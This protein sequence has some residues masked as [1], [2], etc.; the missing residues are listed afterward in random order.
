MKVILEPPSFMVISCSSVSP[1]VSDLSRNLHPALVHPS[2]AL[3]L[4]PYH[5]GL[6]G[7]D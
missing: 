3:G 4:P 6:T 5:Q 1:P 2:A 7:P